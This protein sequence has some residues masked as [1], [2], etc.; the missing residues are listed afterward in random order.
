MC[1][2]L[3]PAQVTHGGPVVLLGVDN[4]ILYP[5]STPE[6]QFAIDGDVYVPYDAAY[7]DAHRD[8]AMTR[9]LTPSSRSAS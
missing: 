1:E 5:Y 3:V 7:Y 6:R 8:T 2:V 4:E 9:L